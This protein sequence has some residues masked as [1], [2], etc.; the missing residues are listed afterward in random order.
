MKPRCKSKLLED[1]E[2]TILDF[3]VKKIHLS[4][5][6]FEKFCKEI[7]TTP[8]NGSVWYKGAEIKEMGE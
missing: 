5:K 3:K 4:K 7:F 1:I 2:K 8:F 6:Q